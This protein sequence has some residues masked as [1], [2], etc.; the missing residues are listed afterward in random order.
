MLTGLAP[1][2]VGTCKASCHRSTPSHTRPWSYLMLSPHTQL[3]AVSS[4]Q[5]SHPGHAIENAAA[6]APDQVTSPDACQT[7][8]TWLRCRSG[9]AKAGYLLAHRCPVGAPVPG[10][11]RQGHAASMSRILGCIKGRQCLHLGRGDVYTAQRRLL[12][13]V[14]CSCC[15][16]S[17]AVLLVQ[18]SS[19][20]A[21]GLAQGC[22]EGQGQ[23]PQV[24]TS[25]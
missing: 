2:I 13:A 20:K 12:Y 22:L 25:T 8:V 24:L 17:G 18:A 9:A 11:K 4:S 14:I 21:G 5:A 10:R 7:H 15:V 6:S 1:C 3:S 19:A 16:G 23:T